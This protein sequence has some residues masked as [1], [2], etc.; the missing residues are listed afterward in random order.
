M[1]K[2]VSVAE[3]KNLLDWR[4][5]TFEGRYLLLLKA[6]FLLCILEI[7]RPHWKVASTTGIKRSFR[8]NKEF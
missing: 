1:Y 3:S 6:V 4:F 2:T 7:V 8:F 5:A